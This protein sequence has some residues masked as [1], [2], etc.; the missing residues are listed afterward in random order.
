MTPPRT[1]VI[2]AVYNAVREMQ[3]ALAGYSRQSVQDL[4]IIVS[5]DGSG[6]EMAAMIETFSRYSHFPIQYL[7][8]PDEG[9]RKCRILNQA[10]RASLGNYLI[11]TDGDC[12]PHSHFVEA[13]LENSRPGTVLCGRRVN[14]CRQ[15]SQDLT[16]NDVLRGKLERGP[17][18]LAWD[19]LLGRITHWEEGLIIKSQALRNGIRRNEPVLFGCNFSLEKSLMERINGFNEDFVEYGAEDTELQHR[20]HLADAQIRW[21]RHQAIQYHLFHPARKRGATSST[22]LE[23]S[24]AEGTFTCRNGLKKFSSSKQSTIPACD[25][26]SAK[27]KN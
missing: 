14:L 6:P 25:H 1:S 13:H 10:I 5:D 21:V 19:R 12:I 20:L 7:H 22:A 3:L 9:F 4:E 18:G 15:F 11:F 26:S 17:L 8:Q 16:V 27:N 23:R 2:I 24:L